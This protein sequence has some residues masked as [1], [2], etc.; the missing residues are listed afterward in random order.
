GLEF[1]R[2]LFRSRQVG[3][4]SPLGASGLGASG[5]GASLFGAAIF[6]VSFLDPFLLGAPFGGMRGSIVLGALGSTR[7]GRVE[8]AGATLSREGFAGASLTGTWG[9]SRGC[10]PRGASVGTRRPSA[11]PQ[12]PLW[13]SRPLRSLTAPLHSF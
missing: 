11:S 13:T 9:R 10:R 7:E 1:R 3:A 4:R 5:F 12:S 2:V 8:T 6:G